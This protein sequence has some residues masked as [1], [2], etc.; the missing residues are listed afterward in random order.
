[1]ASSTPMSQAVWTGRSGLDRHVADA[2]LLL[3]E[4][5]SPCPSMHAGGWP[6]PRSCS[7]IFL[8]DESVR[9]LLTEDAR[10]LDALL[11]DRSLGTWLP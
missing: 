2:A 3:G 6:P 7:A 11:L 8:V 9:G 4:E 10:I 5:A 1:M